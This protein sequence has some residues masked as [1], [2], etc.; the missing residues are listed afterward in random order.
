MGKVLRNSVFS[1][2][3]VVLV[4]PIFFILIPY[5]ISKIGTEGYGV[6]ALTGIIASYQSFVNLGLTSALIRYVAIANVN[7]DKSALSEYLGTSFWVYFIISVFIGSIVFI[8][9]DFIITNVLNL[10]IDIKISRILLISSFVASAINMISGLFKSTI[11]GLQRMDVSNIILLLQVIISAVGTFVFLEFGYGLVGLAYNLIIT[12]ILSLLGNMYSAKVIAGFNFKAFVFRISRLKEMFSYSVNLQLGSIVRA[13]IE[14]MNK[15]LLSHFFSMEHVAFYDIAW[16]FSTKLGG[17]V[18][19]ALTPIL[20]ASTEIYEMFGIEKLELFRKKISKYILSLITPLYVV[21]IV[22]LSA[23]VELW[24]GYSNNEIVF[25][26][27]IFLIASFINA[28][29]IPGYFILNGS[30]YANDTFKVQLYGTVFNVLVIF[31]G[32]YMVGFYGF[33][34]GFCAAL[35]LNFFMTYKFY[36]S[37]FLNKKGVYKVF[38]FPRLLLLNVAVAILGIISVNVFKVDAYWELMLVAGLLLM[39]Y[40]SL[41]RLAKVITPEDIPNKGLLRM[42]K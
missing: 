32:I 1:I 40:F 14:P 9:Q 41:L 16:K 36:S 19:A 11:D 37:R 3:R 26:I 34:L 25:S 30:G 35:V 28:I 8:F 7:Q 15:V 33:A 24:I 22:V 5:I 29:T 6:W 39:I 27:V 13:G 4:T 20:P 42:F 21:I 18:N 10:K 23:F 12:S 31:L 17:L 38:N 2:A